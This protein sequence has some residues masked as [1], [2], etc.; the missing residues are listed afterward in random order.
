MVSW[1]II[2]TG[3]IAYDV[4]FAIQSVKD[5]ELIAVSSRSL[6]NAKKYAD[7]MHISTYLDDYK[8]M[9]LLDEVDIVYISTP[10]SLH[11]ELIEFCLQQGKHVL[12]EKPMVIESFLLEHL[13]E[14]AAQKQLFLMEAMWTMFVPSVRYFLSHLAQ[15]GD[16]KMV[17]GSMGYVLDKERCFKEELGGGAL[18]DLG[19]YLI[20]LTYAFLGQPNEL[21]MQSISQKGNVETTAAFLMKYDDAVANLTCS[22]DVQL[23][24]SFTVYGTKGSLTLKSPFYRTV[25]VQ[26]EQYK[27][28]DGDIDGIRNNFRSFGPL[29]NAPSWKQR[30]LDKLNIGAQKKAI[31][32]RGNGYQYQIQEVVHCLGAHQ[33]ESAIM[34]IDHS[35]KVIK[36]IEKLRSKNYEKDD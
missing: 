24:N 4:G 25:L 7:R 3:K 13:K 35:M 16:I 11:A 19:V 10:N 26:L 33:L 18:F 34:P 17:R 30:I 28:S 32:F 6:K 5:C 8:A 12:C 15:I 20:S 23:D 31:P 36:I 9:I 2:G 29:K 21:V 27:A 1:G 14:L 22:F